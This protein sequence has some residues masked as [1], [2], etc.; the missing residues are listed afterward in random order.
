MLTHVSAQNGERQAATTKTH[1]GDNASAKTRATIEP[2]IV[3]EL[4]DLDALAV[5]DGRRQS[6]GGRG[7]LPSRLAAQAQGGEGSARG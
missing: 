4:V 1:A 6:H 7:S 2:V 5:V 3:L